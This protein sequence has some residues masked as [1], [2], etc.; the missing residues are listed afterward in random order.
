MGLAKGSRSANKSI[1]AVAFLSLIFLF[2][3]F[4]PTSVDEVVE[5][6]IFFKKSNVNKL[7]DD[8]DDDV[9][10]DWNAEDEDA[11]GLQ[12][13]AT[14]LKMSSKQSLS[15]GSSVDISNKSR[16]VESLTIALFPFVVLSPNSD[17]E[18]D[19]SSFIFCAGIS[20]ILSVCAALMS[21]SKSSCYFSE[22]D[23][24]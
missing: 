8:D 13:F 16:I 18:F 17:L 5:P 22:I 10:D 20:A 19:D 24:T 6:C 14:L 2:T 3:P 12:P 15:V 23:I 7:D 4:L 21:S 11:V 9:D 1:H